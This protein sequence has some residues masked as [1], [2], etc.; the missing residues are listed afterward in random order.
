MEP[1]MVEPSGDPF[2]EGMDAFGRGIPLDACPYPDSSDE[3]ELWL[4]GWDEAKRMNEGGDTKGS[5]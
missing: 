3:Q 4:L 1:A 5:P 2:I